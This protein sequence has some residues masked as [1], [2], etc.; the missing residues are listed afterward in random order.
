MLIEV[1]L[2]IV[3]FISCALSYVLGLITAKSDESIEE[4][5]AYLKG[6]KAGFKKGYDQARKEMEDEIL[7]TSC[8]RDDGK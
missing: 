1:V 5:R 7:Y 4:H 8:S 3:C 2:L 6:R